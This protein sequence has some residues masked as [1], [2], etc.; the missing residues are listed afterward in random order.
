[1]TIATVCDSCWRRAPYAASV[2][3]CTPRTHS[4]A[5]EIFSLQRIAR[6]NRQQPPDIPEQSWFDDDGNIKQAAL[7]KLIDGCK[8]EAMRQSLRLLRRV[9]SLT[10][11]DRAQNLTGRTTVDP[12]GHIISIDIGEAKPDMPYKETVQRLGLCVG[13]LRWPCMPTPRPDVLFIGRLFF[14]AMTDLPE[15]VA[16]QKIFEDRQRVLVS[17]KWGY[18]LYLHFLF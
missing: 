7:G 8:D 11:E 1:M 15:D 18:K 3:L 6:M 14:C 17:K 5:A 12:M 16:R 9:L 4:A 2:C 10:K 13:A